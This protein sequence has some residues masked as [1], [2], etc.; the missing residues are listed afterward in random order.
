VICEEQV[1]GQFWQPI[2]HLKTG[3]RGQKPGFSRVNFVTA[4]DSLKNPVSKNHTNDQW[5]MTDDWWLMT[6]D[7][8]LLKKTKFPLKE[9]CPKLEL[10]MLP[11]PRSQNRPHFES[12][13]TS[14]KSESPQAQF[15][16]PKTES[17]T[18]AKTSAPTAK[19]QS[20]RVSEAEPQTRRL[21][22]QRSN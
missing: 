2:N 17:P 4:P 20:V 5:L 16:K 6:A 3:A 15:R 8:W 7:Y 22:R 13:A 12:K 1:F 21:H 19:P 11:K 14:Q 9:I 18:A 10:R